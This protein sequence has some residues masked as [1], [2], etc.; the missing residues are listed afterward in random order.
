MPSECRGD[1]EEDVSWVMIFKLLFQD[2]EMVVQVTSCEG[3]L[4][5]HLLDKENNL[6]L[7]KRLEKEKLLKLV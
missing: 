3:S 7:Y 1:E 2:T 5:G 4:F 6:P